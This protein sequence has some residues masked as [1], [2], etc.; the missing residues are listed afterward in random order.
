MINFNPGFRLSLTDIIFII[1]AITIDIVAA[2]YSIPVAVILFL[3][4]VQFFLFCNV[5]RVRRTP[6]ILWCLLYMITVG[7]YLVYDLNLYIPLGSGL[8]I[9]AV[10]IIFEMRHP[11]YHGILWKHINP[12]L[13]AWFNSTQL[14][15][16]H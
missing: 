1:V 9:G 13:P 8:L 14:L 12:D 2:F 16:N 3:P 4:V 5:F 6:E 15:T 10:F 11:S 7:I